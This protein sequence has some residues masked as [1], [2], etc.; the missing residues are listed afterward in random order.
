MVLK[1]KTG[2]DLPICNAVYDVLYKGQDPKETLGS[3]FKRS[4]KEEF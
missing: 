2:V 3:L 1:E 4:L